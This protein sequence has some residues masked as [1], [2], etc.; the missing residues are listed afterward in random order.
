MSL[1]IFFHI[2]LLFVP[3]PAPVP[4]AEEDIEEEISEEEEAPIDILALSD[5]D[6]PEPPSE[7]LPE[8]PQ[9]PETAAPPPDAV[10]PPPDPN[11]VPETLPESQ[12]PE[13][14]GLE[15]T[16][17]TNTFDPARQ[18]AL[19][20]QTGG[21][22]SEFDQTQDFP[23]Y[24]WNP[25]KEPAAYLAGWEPQRL[26]CFFSFID[27]MNYDL[28]PRANRLKYLT[29]NYGLIVN[30]DLP[31]TFPGQEIVPQPDGYCG[32]DFFVINENGVPAGVYVSA[33][34]VGEGNPPAN[35]ILV[36]WVE[37]PR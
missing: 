3:L 28:D 20:D 31:R 34:G 10:P 15:E 8:S 5:I 13:E 2:A 6:V 18:Q 11:Q 24:A 19:L 4:L 9:P 36:F 33:I 35:V 37:D 1:S 25:V 22:N 32:E 16:P 7:P 27:E 23:L 29:R 26:S 12:L 30:E 14:T 21:I 17:P